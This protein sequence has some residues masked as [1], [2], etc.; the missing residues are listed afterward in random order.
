MRG[1]SSSAPSVHLFVSSPVWPAWAA[2]SK[3]REPGPSRTCPARRHAVTPQAQAPRL[4]QP[5]TPSS[6]QLV[7]K[8]GCR[9]PERFSAGSSSGCRR[10]AIHGEVQKDRQ[11]RRCRRP[12]R[13]PCGGRPRRG[14]AVPQQ[15]LAPGEAKRFALL[16]RPND[17]RL[18]AVLRRR[19]QRCG[20]AR[21]A[22]VLVQCCPAGT[23]MPRDEDPAGFAVRCASP[24]PAVRVLHRR[25]G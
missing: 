15:L 18:I 11:G 12:G 9:P 1:M 24:R 21:R 7:L 16:V 20:R 23:V 17:V 14:P 19:W 3:H 6:I 25:P 8:P 22:A 4:T 10:G 2:Q 5:C 13:F